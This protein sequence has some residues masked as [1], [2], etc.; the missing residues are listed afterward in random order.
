MLVSENTK[1]RDH[2]A[3]EKRPVWADSADAQLDIDIDSKSRLRKLKQTEDE[4][5]V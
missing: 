2:K 3:H 1:R 5:I 4:K